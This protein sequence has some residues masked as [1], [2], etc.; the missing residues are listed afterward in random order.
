M[1]SF[2]TFSR[3]A[4]GIYAALRHSTLFIL[5]FSL[6][7]YLRV[8]FRIR[9]GAEIGRQACLRG[10]CPIG[11]EG[12]NPS[13]G[14]LQEVVFV[15]PFFIRRR[16]DPGPFAGKERQRQNFAGFH[17]GTQALRPYFHPMQVR[18]YG[19]GRY[20]HRSPSRSSYHAY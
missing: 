18:H 17:C 1:L 16:G 9:P 13:P 20:C 4:A 11:R 8:P 6:F 5:H 3:L 12:S 15:P 14:T 10:M 7:S 19:S 2:F